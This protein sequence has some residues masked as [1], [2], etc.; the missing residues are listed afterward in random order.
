MNEET[1]QL[2]FEFTGR[3]AFW[4]ALWVFFRPASMRFIVLALALTLVY[5]ACTVSRDDI[6]GIVK[7]SA[8]AIAY[9]S[10][11]VIVGL[12][13]LLAQRRLPPERRQHRYE[14]SDAGI[15]MSSAV[16]QSTTAWAAY[17]RV[18]ESSRGFYLSPQKRIW[19]FMP[20]R[21][22]HRP[23]ELDRLR[24]LFVE[25]LG[26]RARVSTARGSSI[27]AA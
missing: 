8:L 19:Y 23:G 18:E 13:G 12:S 25:S 3:D 7:L 27:G 21:A 2:E 5:G 10:V 22:L 26:T 9:G 17:E 14:L 11:P 20:K 16:G 4:A 15:S 24:T 6:G 1:V